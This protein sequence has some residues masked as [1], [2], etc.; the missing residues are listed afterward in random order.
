MYM[1]VKT[2]GE[3]L[4]P[5]GVAHRVTAIQTKR[6]YQSPFV[7]CYGSVKTLTASGSGSK[8]E[9]DT[10]AAATPVTARRACD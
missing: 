5:S 7:T 4:V 2:A 8:C 3:D 6:R 9:E 10:S 1:K